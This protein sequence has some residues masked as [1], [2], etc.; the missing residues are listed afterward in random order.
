MC[1]QNDFWNIELT[2]GVF[3]LDLPIVQTERALQL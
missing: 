1:G 3:T 2:G